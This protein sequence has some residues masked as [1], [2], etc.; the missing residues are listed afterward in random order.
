MRKIM[1]GTATTLLAAAVLCTGSPAQA[2]DGTRAAPEASRFCGTDPASGL[3]VWGDRADACAAALAVASAYTKA[4]AGT[5]KGPGT[6]RAGG[7]T[8]KCQERQ[9]DPNPYQECVDA[10]GSGRRVVLSS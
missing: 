1:T 3:A 2:L 6:V 10:S 4:A 9:G 7:V 8:W 5:A